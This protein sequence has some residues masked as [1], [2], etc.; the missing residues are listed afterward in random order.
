MLGAEGNSEESAG[1]ATA[2]DGFY[3]AIQPVA[4]FEALAD[5]GSYHPLP[6]DWWIVAGDI[7]GSTRAIG[8]GRYREVNSVGVAM[9]TAVRNACR[10][11]EIPYVFGGDG[12]TLCVPEPCVPAARSA[13]AGTVAMAESAFGLKLRG[14][15]VP[16]S[17]VRGRSLDVLVARH[18]VSEHFVQCALFGGG[19]EHVE[20]ALKTGWLPDSF[21]VPAD[22]DAEASFQGLECRWDEV[23]SPSEE[24][25]SL[26]IETVG[27]RSNTPDAVRRSLGTYRWVME[28]IREIYGDAQRCRPVVESALRVTLSGARLAREARVKSW[29]EGALGRFRAAVLLRLFALI[30]RYLFWRGTSTAE[31]DWGVYKADL[32]ANTDFRKFDGSMRLVLTGS[33]RQRAELESFLDGLAAAGTIRYGLHV[34]D[35]AVVT[36]LVEKRQGE[37][38]HFVDGAAGG[39]AAAAADLKGKGGGAK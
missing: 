8:E 33:R 21:G 12:A 14:A 30:G 26:I 7:A 27:E 31:T 39:Y 17:Y 1:G 38:F 37:H 10:P 35:A 24:T 18:R 11:V 25:V 22:E 6:E 4:D 32:V 16:V 20:S 36:C 23:P 15:V 5:P 28:R 29:R 3:A 34:S 13:L 2:S 19:A 9:I